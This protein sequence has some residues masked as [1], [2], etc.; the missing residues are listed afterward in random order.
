M[1]TAGNQLHRETEKK[2]LDAMRSFMEQG[3]EPTAGQLCERAGINRSTFYR[4]YPDMHALLSRVERE[5]QQGLYLSLERDGAFLDRLQ[6]G[7]EALLP[8]VT[9]IGA[10]ANFYRVYLRRT[11]CLPME[12]DFRR[13]WREQMTALFRSFGVES[14]EHMHYYFAF[15]KAGLVTVLLRWLEKACPEPP[16]EIAAILA[17]LLSARTAR[18]FPQEG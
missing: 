16:M 7:P 17:Q 14:E 4:H 13:F 3:R 10:H 11:A 9:Y 18:P 12:E 2:L 5:M 1:N 6:A 15:F 8:L